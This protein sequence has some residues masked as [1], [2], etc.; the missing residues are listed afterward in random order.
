MVVGPIHDDSFADNVSDTL[1]R[2]GHSV[3]AVG[4]ARPRPRSAR[5]ANLI[6]I[7]GERMPREDAFLQRRLV[8]SERDFRPDLILTMDRTIQ[9]EVAKKLRA[10]G[11]KLALWYPDHVGNMGRHDM[12]LAGYDRIFL[13]NP[14]L[15]SRLTSIYGIQAEYLPEACNSQWHVSHEDYGVDQVIALAGNVHPTRARLLD[16]MVRAGLPLKIYGSPIPR[17]VNFPALQSTHTGETLR[18]QRKADIFRRSRVVLN[19]LHP[20]EFAGANCRVFEG[21]GAG[22]VVLTESREGMNEL[23]RDGSELLTFGSFE[24][25]VEKSEF[26]LRS[27][28]DG[29]A[30]GDAAAL[31]AH[32]DHTYEH[33]LKQIFDSLDL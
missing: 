11:A 24:E 6:S 9:P 12:F 8:A 22:G 13:K 10:G 1:R 28:S 15:V 29:A 31:R 26:L 23:F 7:L 16:R 14:V 30:I 19:N 25:L 2:M 21:A 27:R 18:R 3:L 33:R 32:R 4:P 20:A 5:I 17:W